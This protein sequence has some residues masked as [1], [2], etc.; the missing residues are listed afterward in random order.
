[1]SKTFINYISLLG[2]TFLIARRAVRHR[3]IVKGF[4]VGLV[5][6]LLTY[7][8]PNDIMSWIQS[9]ISTLLKEKYGLKPRTDSVYYYI[10]AGIGLVIAYTFILMEKFVLKNPKYILHPIY[11]FAERIKNFIEGLR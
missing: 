4:S 7:L 2:I 10:I 3:S 11:E 9:Q 8:L 1:M 6:V 5:M